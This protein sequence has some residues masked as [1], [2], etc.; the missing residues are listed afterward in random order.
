MPH[1]FSR[2]RLRLFWDF[3]RIVVVPSV[4]FAT[5]IC[6][7]KRE[8]CWIAPFAWL[9]FLLTAGYIRLQYHHF[10]QRAEARR[11]GG[12]LPPHVVGKWPGNIDILIKLGK[13]MRTRYP[14]AYYRTLFDEY[15]CTTLNLRLLWADFVSPFHLIRILIRISNK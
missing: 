5:F 9:A 15:K 13:A 2:Y 12:R 6:V 14:G 10:K 7:A 3:V 8:L 1:P 11:H 4:L